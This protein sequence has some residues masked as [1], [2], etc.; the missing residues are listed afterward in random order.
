MN[1]TG[2][3]VYYFSIQY[4]SYQ[5]GNQIITTFVPTSLPSGFT[6]PSNWVEFPSISRTPSLEI[7]NNNFGSFLG[8][9]LDY[10]QF[11]EVV[12]L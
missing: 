3:N 2:Q 9:Q 7:L 5:H 11:L 6:S 8:L 4:N 1:G 12:L 10:I